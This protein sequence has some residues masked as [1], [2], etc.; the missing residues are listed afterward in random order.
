MS[1]F[2]GKILGQRHVLHFE[3]TTRDKPGPP[4]VHP[5]IP[6]V[7][8]LPIHPFRTPNQKGD[9]GYPPP[10]GTFPEGLCTPRPRSLQGAIPQ[11]LHFA[12]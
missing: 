2:V 7:T 12:F 6:S 4:P 3:A 10:F 8:C 5:L 1:Q 9:G 11:A